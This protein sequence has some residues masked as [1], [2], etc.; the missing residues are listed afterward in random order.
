MQKLLPKAAW[1]PVLSAPEKRSAASITTSTS[2]FMKTDL[3]V[4]RTRKHFPRLDVAQIKIAAIQKGGSDR[5]FYRIRCS[6]EQAL[7]LVKYNLEREE[8]RHYVHIA[9]FLSEHRI[10]VPEIYFHDADEALV[11]LEDLGE[12]DLYSYRDESWL[13]R[14]AFYESALGQIATLHA[15]REPVC[16]EMKQHLPAEFNSE[17]YLWEQNYF[18][19]NCLGRLFKIEKSKLAHLASLP[20]LQEIADRLASF[21]RVLVHRDF[22]SQNILIRNGQAYLID[23]QGMR[24]GLAEYDLASL[25]YDPYV[26]LPEDE[27]AE[28]TTYYRSRQ[29][30]NGVAVNGDFNLKLQLCRMQRLMQAL[31]AYGFLGLI[32]GHKHFLRYVPNAVRSLRG[33][34]A[35]IENL[36]EL[37]KTLRQLT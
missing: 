11:W 22:Q 33:V 5:K 32:K 13:V 37:E 2:E 14:R 21:P 3:L 7:I 25:L 31:G 24:P 26:D 28:L 6:A 8:N 34:A 18:F 23:F 30:E 35:K 15:L 19:E 12:R 36:Q 1:R 29:L 16:I 27:R 20:V 9:N 10:R 4:R 17:L